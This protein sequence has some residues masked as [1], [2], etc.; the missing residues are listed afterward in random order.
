[1]A[2]DDVMLLTNKH[3]KIALSCL[4]CAH[5]AL[6]LEHGLANQLGEPLSDAHIQT[7]VAALTTGLTLASRGSH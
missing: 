2:S 1:M 6:C 4:Q 3:Y 5:A 7:L